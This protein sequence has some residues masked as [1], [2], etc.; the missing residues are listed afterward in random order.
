MKQSV[1]K[2]LSTNEIREKI[3]DELA[4]L[5]KLRLTHTITPLENPMKIG[6][7]RK[8]IARLKTELTRR[9]K[10]DSSTK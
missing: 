7:S 8:T 1:V 10:V 3:T 9:S 5:A 6:N 2:E 4:T